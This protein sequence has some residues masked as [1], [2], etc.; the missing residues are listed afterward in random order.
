LAGEAGLGGGSGAIMSLLVSAVA[1]VRAKARSASAG[2]SAGSGITGRMP[3][4]PP[5]ELPVIG[6]FGEDNGQ[7]DADEFN[8]HKITVYRVE[9]LPNTRIIIGERGQVSVQ[10]DRMLFL[11]FGDKGRAEEFL[12][13]RLEQG[14]PEV[15]MKLFEIPRSFFTDLQNAAVPESMARQFPESPLVVDPTKAP[16]QFG[17]RRNQIETLKNSIIQGSGKL[18]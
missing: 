12:V 1:G 7:K 5:P 15:R 10:G 3:G 4:E 14:M 8:T 18:H 11:N 17:L 6:D 2:A 9:G 13:A 16:D